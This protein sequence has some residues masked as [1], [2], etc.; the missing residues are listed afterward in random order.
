MTAPHSLRLTAVVVGLVT[1]V[2]CNSS[3]SP[4]MPDAAQPSSTAS[5]G[6]APTTSSGATISGLVSNGGSAT[7]ALMLM[8]AGG[9]GGVTVTVSGTGLTATTSGT[10]RFS[11][12]SVPAG[13]LTLQFTGA[14]TGTM[15]LD[16]VGEHDTIEIEV[17]V[18]NG[19]VA[20]EQ[21][22]TGNGPQAQLEG[23]I[24][25]VNSGA[26]SFVIGQITVTV[27]STA[28]IR[29]GNQTLTFSNLIAG[30]RVH[31]KGS[32]T[33]ST[34]A[35]TRVE[36][37]Q[38]GA[39]GPG[40]G[41]GNG[42]NGNGGNGNGGNGNGGNGNDD[43]DANEAELTGTVASL[44]GSCPAI[45][46]TASGRSVTTTSST[47]FQLACASITN[48]TKVEVQGTSPTPSGAVTATRVKKEN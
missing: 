37:Q 8:A 17:H 9:M 39:A 11:L 14:A 42:G 23:K 15:S 32:L 45:T 7:G 27:P 33:G 5:G 6:P 20:D 16:D 28:T 43:N 25:S 1:A 13:Q 4:S 36:V 29:H 3:K 41:N 30:A 19:E 47:H 35:A 21:A 38:S 24:V 10:G 22:Q 34:L 12:T 48:G 31:A 2:A 44:G 26:H 40:N 18:Q 46:F